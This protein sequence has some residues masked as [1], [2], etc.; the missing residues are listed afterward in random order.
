MYFFRPQEWFSFLNKLHPVQLI[1][2]FAVYAIYNREKGFKISDI[3]KTPHDWLVFAYFA[4]AIFGSPTPWETFKALQSVIII[5]IIGVQALSNTSRMKGFLGWWALS[6]IVISGL[7]V[8]SEFGFDP[9]G[10]FDLTHGA[11]KDR[12]CLNLS[13]FN[14]PNGLGHSIVPVIP[15]VYFLFFW[16]KIVG[17]VT[18]SL[19]AIPFW[20]IFLTQSKGAFLCA[21]ITICATLTFGRPKIVQ[22]AILA[23][24]VMFG[25]AALYSLPRMNELEKTKTNE[26]IGGRIAAFKFGYQC[27]QKNTFGI[28]LGNFVPEFFKRGPREKFLVK[29]M[30]D[31]QVHR[32]WGFRHFRKA[33]HSAYN[34]N[35]AEL[36]YGGLMLFIAVLYSCLRTLVTMTEGNEDEERI[37]R[38]LF[39]IVTSYVVSCWMVDFAFRPTFFLFVA[40]TGALHRILL[41]NAPESKQEEPE[42]LEPTPIPGRFRP[43]LTPQ[44]AFARPLAKAGV[45]V[46]PRKLEKIVSEEEDQAGM[47]FIRWKRIGLLDVFFVFLL[48]QGAVRLWLYS[49]EKF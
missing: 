32:S 24:A 38:A 44:L 29:K 28:G 33:T 41:A 26:A 20:C 18:L 5:Y 40:A 36:G 47:A 11:M 45:A 2:V 34:Q 13:I 14:N 21:F 49:I 8:A 16:K 23:L 39:P 9:F 22:I 6:L 46:A 27:M 15:M 31:G 19:L 10:S 30:V 7:A 25:T 3:F 12:L 4:W 35:G 48:T 37:R 17:K 1:T 43:V 42:K